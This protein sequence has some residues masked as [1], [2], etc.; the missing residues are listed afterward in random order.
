MALFMVSCSITQPE[1]PSAKMALNKKAFEQEDTYILFA[2]RA[3][4]IGDYRSAS[5][6][7]NTLYQYSG[8]MEY[9][10]RSIRND[11]VFKD[12]NAAIKKVDL[13]ILKNRDDLLA[14]RLKIIALIGLYKYN[15][16][17]MVAV[18]LVK[19]SGNINDY[20][21]VSD[22]YVQL[23]DYETAVK[24]LESAYVKDYSEKIL[25]KMSIVLY[26]NLDRKK[27][28]IAQ[29]ETH[30]RVHGCSKLICSRLIGFYSNENN[31]E[32]LLYAYIKL[33]EIDNSK[34]VADKIVQLYAYKKDYP[35]MISFLERSKSDDE[36]LL[37]LYTNSNNYK[38]AQ[39][40][41]QTLYQKTGDFGYLGQS[42]IYEYEAH[43]NKNDVE[44]LSAVVS[45]LKDVVKSYPS[46]LYMNYLG[47]I[48]ID[49]ELDLDEGMKYVKNALKVEPNSAFYL[50]SLAW[51]YYKM[52]RCKEAK[53]VMD[54]VVTLEGGDD[55]EVISHVKSINECL[56][57]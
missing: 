45:K 44:M 42:A 12:F 47:Y 33:Y 31:V 14:T 9:A 53:E 35:A 57:K 27:D 56:N 3:E 30:S 19:T 23:Q 34:E 13:L 46:P 48:L 49:H 37:Q 32:G 18:E 41:A 24:Y 2:L 28:A 8:K 21:L 22:I 16:A 17:K 7:F 4:E 40:L 5:E 29:L 54:R 20:V 15:E 1:P 39:F 51:G 26:V 38:S 11:L 36:A 55:E 6:L 25:D 43:E 50:D 52:N 10:Y